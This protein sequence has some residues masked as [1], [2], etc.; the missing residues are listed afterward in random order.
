MDRD[1]HLTHHVEVTQSNPCLLCD[2][3]DKLFFSQFVYDSKLHL[4]QGM[5]FSFVLESNLAAR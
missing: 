2:D 1:S 3:D 4:V 5:Y